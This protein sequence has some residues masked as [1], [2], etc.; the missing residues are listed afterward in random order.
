MMA[1][2]SEITNDGASAST[3]K[4]AA[5][6]LYTGTIL[7]K[8][9]KYYTYKLTQKA[10]DKAFGNIISLDPTGIT[11]TAHAGGTSGVI[12]DITVKDAEKLTIT[13]LQ[14]LLR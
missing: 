4:T 11:V 12:Y 1:N 8:D 7:G 5:G 9:G 13:S 14:T 10:Q 6:V 3:T 2:N